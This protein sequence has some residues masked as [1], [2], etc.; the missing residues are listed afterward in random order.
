MKKTGF[1]HSLRGATWTVF[2]HVI[3][4]NSD[5][6][7]TVVSSA[8]SE[9]NK[10]GETIALKLKTKTYYEF[11]DG[12]ERTSHE[13]EQATKDFHDKTIKEAKYV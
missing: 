11:R 4:N 6:L 7:I 9:P 2:E 5:D 12:I 1:G 3:P 13:T 8:W 10:K